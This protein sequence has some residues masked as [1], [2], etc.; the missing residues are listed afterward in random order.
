MKSKT[1]L[2]AGALATLTLGGSLISELTAFEK[3]QERNSLVLQLKGY[4]FPTP[5]TIQLPEGPVDALCY[6]VDIIDVATG[7]VIGRGTDCLYNMAGDGAGVT[8]NNATLF[9]LPGGNLLTLNHTGIQP[10]SLIFGND[11]THVTG[12]VPTEDNIVRGTGCYRGA[13]GIARLQGAVDMSQFAATGELGLDCIFIIE[14]D[15]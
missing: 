5:R 13:E 3:G 2:V 7:E 12:A 14:L 10:H 15:D 11:A 4:A 1:I 9:R 8:L 6:D